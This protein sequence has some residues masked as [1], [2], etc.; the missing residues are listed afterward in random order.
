MRRSHHALL[1]G[2]FSLSLLRPGYASEE[3]AL[4]SLAIMPGARSRAESVLLRPNG[5][6][7]YDGQQ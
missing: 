6:R 4:C 3:S 5:L 1:L 7:N 2:A